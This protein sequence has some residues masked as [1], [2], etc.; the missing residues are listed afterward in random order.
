MIP[1]LLHRLLA[2]AL[3]SLFFAFQTEL[4]HEEYIRQ[5]RQLW[6]TPAI[7][8]PSVTWE[9]FDKENA[10]KA[11]VFTVERGEGFVL[12]PHREI[13]SSLLPRVSIHPV[14]DKS[15]PFPAHDSPI[16]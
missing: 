6:A 12:L 9:T 14:R 1:R 13:C 7:A 10:Q 11:F 3:A 8:A 16:A 15:P 4:D 2:I 5:Q